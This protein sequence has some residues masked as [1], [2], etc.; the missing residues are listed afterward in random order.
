MA[1][2]TLCIIKDLFR[3]S[4]IRMCH[5]ILRVYRKT[6]K[7]KSFVSELLVR[8]LPKPMMGQQW[9]RKRQPLKSFCCSI[10]RR[11]GTESC[12][13]NQRV[14]S[15]SARPNSPLTLKVQ[16]LW[17]TWNMLKFVEK[18]NAVFFDASKASKIK[19]HFFLSRSDRAAFPRSR[20]G[21]CDRTRASRRLPTWVCSRNCPSD[22]DGDWRLAKNGKNDEFRWTK[23]WP[24]FERLRW[25]SI[26]KV[27]HEISIDQHR[28]A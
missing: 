19:V 11:G 28:L 5:W 21:E 18:D 1:P 16:M 27:I 25:F 9:V 8:L 22:R 13:I 14:S 12:G 6:A 7:A 2:S 3:G 26:M 23:L 17:E 24:D 15:V 20:E 10:S 4:W